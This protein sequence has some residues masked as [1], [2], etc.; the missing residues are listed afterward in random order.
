MFPKRGT[1][2]S[3][4]TA[5]VLLI[6]AAITGCARREERTRSWL[7]FDTIVSLRLYDVACDSAA[8]AIFALAQR[9]LAHWDS[10]ADPYD[11]TSPLFE[12]NHAPPG[13]LRVDRDLAA[14]AKASIRWQKATLGALEPRIGH[15][16]ELWGVGTEHPNLPTQREVDSVLA[17]VRGSAVDFIGDDVAVVRGD[18]SLDLGAIAKGFAT[19]D[20]FD[21][22]LPLCRGGDDVG[23]FLIDGGRTL[24]GWRRNG[25][26]F[27]IGIANPRGEGV[28]AWFELPSEAACASSG[29]YERFFVR[30]GE[31][32]HHIFDPKTGFPARGAIAATVVAPDATTADALSTAAVV[33]GDEV[34][35]VIDAERTTVILFTERDGRVRWKV[36]GKKLH[37]H[38]VGE[39]GEAR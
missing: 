12:L 36:L 29:D 13:T 8:D 10:I 30:G 11:S 21:T 38:P 23:G 2:Q 18:L 15:I 1:L 32:Y 39:G 3:F 35:K 9:T 24:R 27:R 28:I 4:S 19:D 22:L 31:R 16:V 17:L 25:K 33:M 7:Y 34:Q 14:L 37:V 20:L 26:P 5:A 6:T